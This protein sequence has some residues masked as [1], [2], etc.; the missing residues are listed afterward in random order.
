MLETWHAPSKGRLHEPTAAENGA[1]ERLT[2]VT[3][4]PKRRDVQAPCS[5]TD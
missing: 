4:D 1:I 3:S 2:D 5:L